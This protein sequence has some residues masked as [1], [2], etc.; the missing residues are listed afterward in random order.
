MFI[1]F[2]EKKEIHMYIKTI[3]FESETHKMM[4][5]LCISQPM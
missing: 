2:D 4:I 1:P 5:N 3:L